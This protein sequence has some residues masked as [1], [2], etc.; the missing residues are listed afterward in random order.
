MT[1]VAEAAVDKPLTEVLD[2]LPA[3]LERYH[4]PGLQLAAVRGGE[5]VLAAGYGSADL[6]TASPATART[7][8]HHGSCGKAYTSLLAVLLAEDKLLDLDAPV[9]TYVPELRL[10]DP[11]IAERVTLRDLLSHRSGLARHD[12]AWILNASWTAQDVVE[13]LAHLPL[14]GD[15][16]TQMNYSNFGYALAGI[17]IER[18]SG[19]AYEEQL[20]SRI[21]DPLGLARTVSSSEV[22]GADEDVAAPYV[23]RDGQPVRTEWRH[24]SAMAAAGGV[25]SC[26]EDSVRWL[27]LQLGHGPIDA[28]VVGR[29]HHLNTPVPAEMANALPDMRLYGYAMGWV[30]GTMRGHR[31]LWHSGGI[32]G[33]TT[34]VLL[35]PDDDI[36]VVA[37][38]NVHLTQT[39]PLALVLDVADALLGEASES[40]WTD[41]LFAAPEETAPAQ[42]AERSSAPTQP[43]GAYVGT[44]TNPG[45]GQLDVALDNKSL[46]FRL[47]DFTVSSSHRHFDTWDT[48]YEP[49]DAKATVT[50]VTDA[51][52]SI[53]EAVVEFEVEESGPIRYVRQQSSEG[54]S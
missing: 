6:E 42:R 46:S 37:S 30:V 7:L 12:M 29:T 28:D 27:Q 33:F 13:R 40:F 16:R 26:A 50:F 36:G 53:T 32:D 49:L 4:A 20:R 39:L 41:R 1:A 17:A 5:T 35:L 14:H 44:F 9:R 11:V 8:F 19:T 2:R 22:G 38:V 52:A 10:L 47:G 43:L 45:Y 31:V 25:V 24:M 21:F 34:Y 23:V 3:D 18:V 54:E 51:K 15:L 48:N